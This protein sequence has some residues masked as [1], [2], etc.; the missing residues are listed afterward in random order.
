[1]AGDDLLLASPFALAART[2]SCPIVSSIAP[3]VSRA[4]QAIGM[5]LSQARA[6]SRVDRAASARSASRSSEPSR[7]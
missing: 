4:N 6:G 7:A 1:V 2:Y 5:R 3:R